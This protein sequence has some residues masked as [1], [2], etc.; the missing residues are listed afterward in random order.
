MARFTAL[1]SHPW[2]GDPEGGGCTGAPLPS[3]S[4]RFL[5]TLPL[6]LG[7]LT[8]LLIPLINEG[9]GAPDGDTNKAR[10]ALRRHVNISRRRLVRENRL[11]SFPTIHEIF[12]SL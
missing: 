5:T 6:P 7:V 11:R 12:S 1:S 9:R 4:D 8:A 2:N 10:R 3:T